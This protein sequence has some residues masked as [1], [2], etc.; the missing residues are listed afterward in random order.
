[1]TQ[2]FKCNPCECGGNPDCP[3]CDDRIIAETGWNL[4]SVLRFIQE[5][6]KADIEKDEFGN[7][8]VYPSLYEDAEGRLREGSQGE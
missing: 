3:D 6:G 4:D 5:T 1:M 7:I 8:C 2:V